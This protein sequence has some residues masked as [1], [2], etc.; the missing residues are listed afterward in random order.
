[1]INEI[2]FRSVGIDLMNKLGNAR[3]PFLFLIFKEK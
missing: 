2:P 1:M 3:T